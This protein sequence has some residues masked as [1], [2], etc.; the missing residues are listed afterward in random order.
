MSTILHV[1]DDPLLADT[2]KD[3]FE[4]FGFRGRYLVAETIRDAL[5]IVEDGAS[6]GGLPDLVIS[7]MSLPD[8]TGLDLLRSV[9]SDPAR[10]HVPIVI[11]SGNVDR[12]TVNRA[13]ALG[14]NA[15]LSKGVRNRS[16]VDITSTL[17]AHWFRDVELPTGS[18]NSTPTHRYIARGIQIRA[19]L[20]AAYMKIAETL[21]SQDGELWIDLALREGNIENLL[22][23]LAGQLG[24]RELPPDLLAEAEAAQRAQLLQLEVL[25]QHPVK[26]RDDAVRYMRVLVS[27]IPAVV[28]AQV[29]A[30][31]F[32][33]VP[34][35]MSTL[36]EVAASALDEMAGWIE[37]HSSDRLLRDHIPRLR[38]DA[39]RFRA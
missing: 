24:T 4:A 16:I 38:A 31:L 11:L 13:Y 35:A 30:N 6:D 26:T 20:G 19:R 9:R 23:F 5:K 17:Y 39:A 25:E 29:I 2:V 15:Y 22:A 28:F 10:R 14:A 21:D 32:P 12:G 1:E 8:G 7:D 33:V 37:A 3:A 34:V 27:N 36:R 18:S